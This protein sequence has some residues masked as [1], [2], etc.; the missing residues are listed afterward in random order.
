MHLV[1]VQCM[2]RRIAS[3]QIKSRVLALVGLEEA[4]Q[5]LL[6]LK[7]STFLS[8]FCHSAVWTRFRHVSIARMSTETKL[9]ALAK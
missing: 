9:D 2:G 6:Y 7:R 1:T 5:H 8:A 3:V 4:L